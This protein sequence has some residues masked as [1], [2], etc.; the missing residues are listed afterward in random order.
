MIIGIDVDDVVANLVD[1]WLARYNFDYKDNLKN[2]DIT[3]WNISKFVKP[4]CGIKIYD[5]LKDKT[6]YNFVNPVQ[7][8]LNAVNMLKNFGRVVFITAPISETMGEKYSWLKEHGYI[9]TIKDYIEATDKDLIKCN[10]L[11]DDGYHNIKNRKGSFLFS[12]PWNKSFNYPQRIN[13]WKEFIEEKM[14]EIWRG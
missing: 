11:I 2:K 12:R 9:D 13:S 7:N 10:F 5:Y 6:L 3:E 4:K 1:A 8:S 14:G